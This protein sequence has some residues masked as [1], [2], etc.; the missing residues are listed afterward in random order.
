MHV[1]YYVTILQFWIFF[2]FTYYYYHVDFFDFFLTIHM[3]EWGG[4]EEEG[5]KGKNDAGSKDEAVEVGRGT[6]HCM[7]VT[8]KFRPRTT[9]PK[10]ATGK[11]ENGMEEQ[12]CRSSVL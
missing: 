12:N 1:L 9:F 10:S 6:G 5:Y 2:K 7:L 3:A 8:L 11:R 4:G